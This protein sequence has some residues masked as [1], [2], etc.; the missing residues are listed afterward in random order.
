MIPQPISEKH[1]VFN[2]HDMFLEAMAHGSLIGYDILDV[3]ALTFI[4]DVNPKVAAG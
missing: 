4:P 3:T 2:E 1:C